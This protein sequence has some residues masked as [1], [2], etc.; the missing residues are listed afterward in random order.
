LNKLIEREK[1]APKDY[2]ISTNGVALVGKIPRRKR[3]QK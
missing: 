1:L 2:S 3:R